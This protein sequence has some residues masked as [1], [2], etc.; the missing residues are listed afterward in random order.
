M[1]QVLVLGG[2]AAVLE[3]PARPELSVIV[4]CYRA[5]ESIIRV[6]A[7]LHELL[8]REGISF[9][10]VLVANYWPDHDDPTPAI[11]KR[12]AEEHT[13]VAVVSKPKEG[14]MGWD[15]R[16][17]FDAAVGET[18]VLIDGDSQNPVDDALLL[19][20]LMC[21]RG[22]DV[23]KGRRMTRHD[24]VYRKTMSVVYNVLFRALFGTAGVWDVNG[25]PKGLTRRAYEQ[26]RICSDD[27]FADAEIVLEAQRLGLAIAELPVNF[28]RNDD[29]ASFVRVSAIWEFAV[30]MIRYRFRGEP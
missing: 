19:F 17:G 14:A 6:V 27:W 8:R 23:G 3:E 18:M 28:N 22:A 10:L 1:K 5:G 29:R 2:G 9:E 15:L 25:K 21:E 12:F 26:M 4:L 20:R 24:G 7:P 30:H 11:V 13:S 16:S